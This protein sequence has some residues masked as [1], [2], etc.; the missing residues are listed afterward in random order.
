MKAHNIP[1]MYALYADEGHGFA[2]PENRLSHYALTEQFLARILGGRAEHIGDVLV[3]A[4]F[5]L[6]GN[7][8]KDGEAAEKEIDKAI[9]G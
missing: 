3:L 6:N 1:V 8:V 5:T 4:N 2:R 7:D 9:G